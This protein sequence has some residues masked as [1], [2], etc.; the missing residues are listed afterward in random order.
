MKHSVRRWRAAVAVFLA[1]LLV[2]ASSAVA[3]QVRQEPSRF[4]ALVV[5][6]PSQS[7]DVAT[8]PVA[9]L[10]STESSRGAWEAF[11][12]VHGQAWSVYLD[13]RSGAPL[14]VEGR[15]LPWP[16]AKGATVESIAASL[17]TFIAG[18]KT[19]LFADNA[20]LV[21]DR[22]ASGSL[23]PD[24]WQIAF[25][26][27]IAGVPVVGE[28]YVFTIGHG[29]LISF[30]ATRWSRI[31]ANPVPDIE[32]T[33]ALSRL[34]A[35]MG[36]NVADGVRMIDKGSLQL[37]SL[38][39]GAASGGA[40]SGP[41]GAG[42]GSALVWRLALK[43][44]GEPGTWEALIDAHTGAIRSF[45]DVNDYAQAKGGVYPVSNDQLPPDGVEQADYP[46][47]FTD[48][49]I[50]AAPQTTSSSG[51]FSCTPG[52]A[53][54][55][56]TLAGQYVRVVD[57]CGAIS[58]SVSCDD[59][60]DLSGSSGTDCAVPAGSSAGNTHAARTGFYHLNRIAEHGRYWLPTRTWLAAQ[61]TDNVNLNQTCNAYWDG[62]SVNFFK[63]GGGCRNTG[64]IAGIFLH[65]W[66]HGL[67]ANDGGGLDN[68]S[69]AYADVVAFM[70]THV[71]CIGRGFDMTNNCGGYG[72]ACLNCTGIRDVDYAAR[73]S[74]TP[75]TPSGFLTTYCQGGSGPCGKEVHCEGYVGAET[76][77]DLAVRDL[78]AS[79]LDP[80]SSWQLADKLWYKSRLG[81]GGNAYNCALPN[82]DG[83][84]ATSWFTKLRTIDDDD[85]NLANGTPHAAAIYA[86][87]NRHKIAC[88]LAGDASN[89]NSS[90][91]PALGTPVL[92]ATAR[93]AAAQLDWT[94]VAGATGYNV[95]RN[96]ASCASGS[97]IIATVPGTSFTDTGLANGFAEYYAVQAV[98]ANAACDG[99][100]SNCQA[101]IPQ[102][103]AGT[104]KLGAL[105]YS[106]SG[107]IDVS[108]KD[109]N[110]G[111]PTT[112]VTI[113]STTEPTGET[114]TL[115]QVSPGS[116]NYAGTLAATGNPP[117]A[118][119]LISVVN[120]DTI[121]ATY[122]DAND[123]QG[124][125]NL[126]RTTTATT[127][128]AFPIITNVAASLVTGNSA[129][130]TW[131]TDEAATSVVRYGL[132]PP[133]GSTTALAAKVVGHTVDLTGLV[134]CSSYVYAV[135][136]TDA[137]GNPALDTNGGAYYTFTTGQ[138]VAP[139]YGSTDTPVAIPDN[140][141]AGAASTITVPDN[142]PVQN[143]KVTVNITHTYDG[144]LTLTLIPPIGAPITLSAKRGGFGDD[145]AGTVFDDSAATS[146][147]TGTAPFMGPFRPETP[148]ATANG[149]TAAGN[150][151][152]K[153]VDSD[154]VDVG[155]IDS[156]T[157]SLVYPSAACG[158]N[159]AY[160][161][162]ASIADTC[163]TGGIGEGNTTWDAGEQIN[164]KV[165]VNND[166]TATLT[167]VTATVT[168]STPGVVMVDG[169][170]SYPDLVTATAAE[171][172]APHFTAFLPTSLACGDLVSFQITVACDQG[173]WNTS[174]T[175]GVGQVIPGSGT[176]LNETF[177]AG[178]PAAWTIVDG[179]L[180]GG[181]AATW[182]TA[183]P[184]GRVLASPMVAPAAIVDSDFAGPTATQNEELITPAM[185]LETATTVTLQ[186][187]QYFN[188]YSLGLAEVADVD[189]RS[190][191]TGDTWVNVLRQQ[192]T[193]SPN[194][195]HESIDIS[196]QAA[197]GSNVQVRF[198][199][200]NA[201]YE[202]YW[203]VDN[204]KV[205]TTSPGS[206]S[207]KVCAAPP[208]AAKPVADGSFG[209]A[210]RGSRADVPGTTIDLT[211]D[212]ATCTSNDHHVLY[213]ALADVATSTVG[214][215]SCN[216]GATGT[217]VWT[218]VPAGDL[219]FVVVGDN[220]LTL[221]GSWGTMTSGE[222]GGASASGQ[223]G[224]TTRNYSSSC[225]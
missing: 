77:W 199:Y 11:R 182:T 91:C 85:G 52:G 131:D 94:A 110:I 18:S 73:A 111:G 90:T 215:A 67:D 53:T 192:T 166:G 141:P 160:Q 50:N 84:G 25:R 107:V 209:A 88:G 20:E 136:S 72:D 124:G 28:R 176:P 113:T 4:D 225:P 169:T 8:T 148:L 179:G 15:G 60:L 218:G 62:T 38:R 9:S 198:H 96:D 206:C 168:S 24:V 173:T 155:T 6:D 47:P 27:A 87:F 80:A 165:S 154:N 214:G 157:L 162:H 159:A 35:Y 106:C 223:C 1:L 174:F 121:T 10:P 149:I 133:P 51:A 130:V 86:A 178:I 187:D 95:L 61:L 139:D 109:A 81:S 172:L 138:N 40:Y 125:V 117:A 57:T 105:S 58:Q 183:N 181:A 129:R 12:A 185:N 190:T 191:L 89:Q 112:T 7:L 171:S 123:G 37:I 44:E 217:A 16:I 197:G 184:G 200:Y 39:A 66:G 188:R 142:K 78:P 54:A 119:G 3:F 156:W 144:D 101:V 75:A 222:R 212:V 161:S 194:P 26:R 195:D 201:Q 43:V 19:L 98:G 177:T 63:S 46:M 204:V 59:D 104:V 102:P 216:L 21:L 48:I 211:W 116:A 71:S 74:N 196:A 14:L 140:N 99:R 97:T 64:E 207:Q 45:R 208:G 143:V 34:T 103:F 23:S 145:F 83:C 203:Q 33:E 158:P 134:P 175:H 221:E 163:A 36:L 49:T 30:G 70:S 213:G 152:L 164:F 5:E 76:L 150:W 224:L 69:E 219:W 32:A 167:H 31:D 151:Q 114:I 108:V 82:S 22:P 220:N 55:T 180:G 118:D 146:I 2:T 92:T 186:F 120:G 132:T 127:D 41:L 29:N 135:E 193:S 115:T 137:V 147:T 93:S 205:D 56:T 100:L 202:F 42:Y 122:L 153:V 79:G 17:R 126:T 189:V 170:A 13:R 128:C 68:P 65:E 210:M